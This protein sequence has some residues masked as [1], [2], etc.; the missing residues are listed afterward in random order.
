M[1]DLHPQLILHS[2]LIWVFFIEGG[3]LFAPMWSCVRI[4]GHIAVVSWPGVDLFH[5]MCAVKWSF[6]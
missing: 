6:E 5:K 1:D 3:K 4:K 2:T